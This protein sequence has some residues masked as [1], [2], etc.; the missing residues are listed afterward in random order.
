ME[1]KKKNSGYDQGK[2]GGENSVQT[3]KSRITADTE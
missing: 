2:K 3:T 1:K